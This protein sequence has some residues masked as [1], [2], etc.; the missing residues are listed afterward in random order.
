MFDAIYLNVV[1]FIFIKLA[2]SEAPKLRRI[3]KIATIQIKK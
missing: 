1:N 3:K 2:R